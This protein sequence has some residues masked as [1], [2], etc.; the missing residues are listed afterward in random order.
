MIKEIGGKVW[1]V[2]RGIDP[3]WFRMYRYWSRTQGRTRERMALGK[4]RIQSTIHN[5]GTMDE[6]RSQVLGPVSRN[7]RFVSA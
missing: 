4:C 7:E 3:V 5:N 6:L 2:Q 1:R